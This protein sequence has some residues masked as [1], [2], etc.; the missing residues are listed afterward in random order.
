MYSCIYTEYTVLTICHS[1]NNIPFF[2]FYMVMTVYFIFFSQSGPAES[3]TLNEIELEQFDKIE[4]ELN[5]W[6]SGHAAVG[7]CRVDVFRATPST[8]LSNLL[9]LGNTKI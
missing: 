9:N 6:A 2:F 7:V 8:C 3:K 4:L 1:V 5:E